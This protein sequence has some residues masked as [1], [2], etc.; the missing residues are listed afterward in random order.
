MK[1]FS[2]GCL[3]ILVFLISCTDPLKEQNSLKDSIHRL[4]E[5]IPL[6]DKFMESDKRMLNTSYYPNGQVKLEGNLENNLREGKWTSWYET[7]MIWS[8]TCFVKGVKTGPTTTWYANGK[9]RYEGE[10]LNNKEFGEWKYYDEVGNL[11]DTKT[12]H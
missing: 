1:L 12:F 5:T 6:S 11:A 7:G 9:K 4:N 3:V 8:E 2:I 10:Y